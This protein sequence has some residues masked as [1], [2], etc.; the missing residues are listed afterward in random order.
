MSTDELLILQDAEVRARTSD[1][2][3]RMLEQRATP[4]PRDSRFLDNA[5]YALLQELVN[6]ILPQGAVGTGVDIA[7]GIDRRLA[8]G[9]NAGWRF[10]ELPE[11]GEAYRR[12]LTIFETML[13]QTP[14][15]T[16][17]RMPPPAREGYLRCVANGDVDGPSGFPLSKWLRM[18]RTDV[19]KIWVSHPDAMRVMEYYG[20]ADGATGT[21]D[22]PAGDEGWVS[23]GPNSAVPFEWAGRGEPGE[24]AAHVPAGGLDAAGGAR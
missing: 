4:G 1:A 15:K 14:M 16:F 17:G 20:F 3:R 18:V 11:D 2:T 9:S 22:G 7:D 6:A 23:I 19:V 21:T 13:Q 8:E 24:V 12:G 5:Q 10:A